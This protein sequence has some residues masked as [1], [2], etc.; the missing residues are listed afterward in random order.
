MAYQTFDG[1]AGA[2]NSAAKLD[3][4]KLSQDLS[5]KKVLD[6]GCNEGF[7]CQ[8]AVRRGASEVVGIDHDPKIIDKA[9]SRVPEATFYC[10]SWW[11]IPGNN[12]DVILFLSAIHYEPRQK[13]LLDFLRTKLAP[14][15]ILVLECGVKWSLS[16]KEWVPIQR[17]DGILRFPTFPLLVEELL[18]AYATRDIGPSVSQAGDPLPRYIFHCTP[19][20]PTILIISGNSRRGKTVL[21]REL[22]SRDIPVLYM[23]FFLGQLHRNAEKYTHSFIKYI[24]ENFEQNRVDIF[25]E[26]MVIDNKTAD[27]L[28]FFSYLISVEDPI[29]IVEGYIF[30]SHAVR[31]KMKSYFEERGFVVAQI[32]L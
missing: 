8:E 17:H 4:L 27:F 3:A 21:A 31:E 29:T 15:G 6:I 22:S 32:V 18:S 5:G 2:S 24:K 23:D 11:D 12:Y 26:K 13:L 9:K 14:D 7:F 10:A 16:E 1:Q 20:K 25:C 30:N 28:N 19:R